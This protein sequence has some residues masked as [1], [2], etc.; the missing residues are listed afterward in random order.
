[1]VALVGESG[2]GKSASAMAVVG[3]LPEFAEV[4]GSVRLRGEELVG[5]S[6]AQMSQ[7]RGN[8]IG[9]VFQDPMSALTPVYT[10]G[11]QIAEAL[12]GPQPRTWAGVRPVPGRSSCSSWWASPNPS[13]RARA[14]PHELSGGERQRVVIAIAI[15]NDPD[16]LICDEP[17]TA[18]DVTVQAQI[19]EVL[20]TARDVTG[21]GVLIITHD[22]GVVAEFA[23][24]AMVMYAGRAVEDAR[25]A[26]LYEKRPDALHRRP[27]RLGATPG[28]PAGRPPGA[29]PRCTA[30][31]HHDAA[32][33][34][35]RP[36]L[37]AGH[38]RMR[39]PPNPS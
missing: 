2:A 23:D 25:C 15:A 4:S 12:T 24:R 7:V 21:A 27:A 36:A 37:P 33:L 18:L 26:R 6:D 8:T 34:P 32:R 39:R 31:A 11:D 13:R 5:L 14:F 35:V 20:K 1:M 29:D 28:R 10:V 16:L 17:T 19:L 22:L 30:V 9:T 38:R 3:L